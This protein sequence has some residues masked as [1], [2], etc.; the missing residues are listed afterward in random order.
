MPYNIN[1]KHIIELLAQEQLFKAII[2]TAA[3][4]EEI[5]FAR[6]V[7]NRNIPTPLISN[8]TLGKLLE[9]SKDLDM[10]VEQEKYYPLLKDFVTLR[11]HCVHSGE[12]L[13]S[14][15]DES[16][17]RGIEKLIGK[18]CE[19]IP[20]NVINEDLKDPNNEALKHYAEDAKK[21]LSFLDKF[22]EN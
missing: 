22:S 18:M 20:K 6:L 21:K 16:K 8:W 9:A 15:I 5:F 2:E 17:K 10:I 7:H 12:Y 13:I 19:F 4:L 11:N 1:S 14:V 3:I